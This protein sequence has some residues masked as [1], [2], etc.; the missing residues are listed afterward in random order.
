M[1]RLA[2]IINSVDANTSHDVEHYHAYLQALYLLARWLDGAE[3]GECAAG[4]R[5][6]VLPEAAL[7][8]KQPDLPS[9]TP[10][11]LEWFR[12][13]ADSE[14]LSVLRDPLFRSHPRETQLK[15]LRQ[16]DTDFAGMSIEAQQAALDDPSF[17]PVAAG[18]AS[19]SRR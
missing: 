7:D 8:T 3:I 12:G 19:N 10:E 9:A 11:Y 4:D 18:P 16:L 1:A 15:V 13:H 14:V 5:V 6:F 17:Q 2:G